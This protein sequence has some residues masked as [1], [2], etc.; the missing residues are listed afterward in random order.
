MLEQVAGV[1]RPLVRS[2]WVLRGARVLR[3]MGLIRAAHPVATIRLA[4]DVRRW[5]PVAGAVRV[6]AQRWPD[7]IG[8]VDDRGALT[9]G[10]LD[11]R[12]NAL[13]WAWRG[14]GIRQDSAVGLLGRN[15]RSMV[16][17]MLAAAKLGAQV[18][19]MRPDLGVDELA[20][21]VQREG[22]TAIAYDQEFAPALAGLPERVSRYLAWTD[23]GSGGDVMLDEL[24]AA[25]PGHE[26]PAPA[27]PGGLTLLA[28]GPVTGSDAR[29]RA[30]P[31]RARPVRLAAQ[32]LDRIPLPPGKAVLVALPLWRGS[33]LVPFLVALSLGSAVV[34]PRRPEAVRL[35]ANII[36]YRCAAAVLTPPLLDDL[37][38]VAAPAPAVLRLVVSTGA[39]LA[40]D[41]G[42]RVVTQ[43]GDVLYN[44]YCTSAS[45]VAAVATPADWRVAPGTVGRAPFGGE[46][47]LFARD[48]RRLVEPGRVG[49]VYVGDGLASGPPP[50]SAPE[51]L[52]GLLPT[53]EVGHFDR[54][55]RL[56]IDGST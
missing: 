31:C 41:L 55:G 33:G 8:L 22:V 9:F 43:F 11:R 24:I 1:S 3:R 51:A 13:A 52:A 2:R 29:L 35:L 36:R 20:V 27:E 5:G 7:A 17:A 21:L 44:W 40:A 32:F 34:L 15:H 4:R 25:A 12:S 37:V 10:E 50:G 49:A 16:D 28:T 26:P 56:F 42:D 48:G 45:P 53:R 23:D 47:G 38:A 46:V 39:P 19:P 54:A 6:A 18:V 14:Q 30:V